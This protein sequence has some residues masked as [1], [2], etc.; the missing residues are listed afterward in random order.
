MVDA[1]FVS[2]FFFYS[3]MVKVERFDIVEMCARKFDAGNHP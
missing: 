3:P 1:Q 2:S